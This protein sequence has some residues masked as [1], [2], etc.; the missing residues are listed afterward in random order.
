MT[1]KKLNLVIL[2]A[3]GAILLSACTGG[4]ASLVNTWAGLTADDTRAYLASGSHVYAVDIATG[5]EV[6]RYP[7]E[8]DSNIIFYANPV[9]T[10]DGQ[11]L[12]GSEGNNHE[13][14]SIDPE[15][16]KDNWAAP[17]A[18][19]MGKWV[20][21][22]LVLN[23]TIYAPNSDGFLYILNM[24]G[25]PV[26]DPIELGG[27]LWS[28]PVT[29]GSL[30]YVTA[31]DHHLHIINP[32]TGTAGEPV[33]LG[34]AAP[35]SPVVG[36]G[37][38]YVGSFSSNIE[39]VTSNGNHDVQATA[40]NWIWGT[41]A[42][43][44]DTLYYADLDGVLYS[45]DLTTGVQNWDA[46]KPDG[47]IVASPLVVGEKIYVVTESGSILALDRDAKV[48]WEKT[49]EGKLYTTPVLSGETLLIAPYRAEFAL[50]AYDAEG[51]QAWTFT[52]EK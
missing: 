35:S 37:G 49:V 14:V 43:D 16:G 3:L 5:K 41:P 29:D 40:G 20:G 4:R 17:F 25:E 13:L 21:S 50:A 6:W 51:K 1:M 27:A 19:A 24:D 42:L 8:T 9:L 39:F 26:S 2:L 46:V 23:E 32:A 33:D 44:N 12:A 22:P 11:L 10:S 18:G 31:L 38:V 36:D 34:G 48:I 52:P 15:T 7:A 28:A 45:L 30:I 47:P